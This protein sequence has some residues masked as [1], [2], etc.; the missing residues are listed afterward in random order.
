VTCTNPLLVYKS[1]RSKK[2]LFNKPFPFAKGFNV[3]CGQ[4][5]GCRKRK[6]V[7][8]A[9]RMVHE[10]QM[11]EENCFITLTFNDWELEKRNQA[12]IKVKDFQLFMKKL[13]NST[14]KK[15][16]FFHCGEYGKLRGRPHYHAILFG[17]DFPDRV[18]WKAENGNKL[19]ISDKL[20]SLWPYGWS[21]VGDVTFASAQYVA[22]YCTKKITG[23]LAE[24]HYKT[25]NGIPV[26][27]E[28]CT[29]SRG[30]N[31][32]TSDPNHTRGIGYTF[33]KKY[34]SDIYPHDFCEIDGKQILPPRYYDEL[35]KEEDPTLYEEIKQK[36]IDKMVNPVLE[37]LDDPL[38]KRFADIEELR[39]HREKR[40]LRKYELDMSDNLYYDNNT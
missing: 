39:E 22:K 27:P 24:D 37:D 3:P 38:R 16:R 31:L 40:S 10:T 19:Y 29:M 25:V 18:L 36:R 35:L 8:W 13:R 30:N 11:H 5:K 6:A 23:D 1:A 7:Q 15:I 12:S 34:K 33:Y 20:K 17:Y 14:F 4:C 28:Y 26:T 32:P 2:V 21:S 9:I